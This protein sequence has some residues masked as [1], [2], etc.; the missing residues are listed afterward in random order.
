MPAPLALTAGLEP[1]RSLAFTDLTENVLPYWMDHAFDADG[2][3]VGSVADDGTPSDEGPRSAVLI[4][5]MVWTFAAAAQTVPDNADAYLATGRQALEILTGP[6]WDHDH[7][8]VFWSIDG[9]GNVID[10][11]KHIYAQAFA[12][13]AL[14][15][16][17]ITTGEEQA[18]DRALELFALIETH[19]RDHELGGYIEARSREWGHLENMALSPKDLNVPKS[20]N[21]NLHVMEALTTLLRATGDDAVGEALA[22]V[23]EATVTYI[24]R[25]E[26]WSHCALFFDQ[27]WNRIGDGISYGHDIEASWLIWDAHEALIEAGLPSDPDVVMEAT[28]GLA[29]AVMEHGVDSDGGVMYE[30]DPT[31]VLIGHKHWWPQ[32]EGIV[33][34]LNAYQVT[35]R[36]EYAQTVLAVARFVDEYQIDHEHGEWFAELERDRS[37]RVGAEGEVKIGPWKCPYHNGRGWIEVLKRVQAPA[38]ATP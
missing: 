13:Y 34:W 9:D 3:L 6:A 32:A 26:P 22:S 19:G 12:V 7:G 36:E 38:D 29:D 17:F 2:R 23:T 35:G 18:R 20:M 37:P 25:H 24:V 30:G 27:E 8:G 15:Q 11:R 1:L 28:V 16:W 10:P 31:G 21:T 4:A 33:G 14:A 5:R